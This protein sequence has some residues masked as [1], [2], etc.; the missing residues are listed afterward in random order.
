M[1]YWIVLFFS[2]FVIACKDDTDGTKV[3]MSSITESVYASGIVKAQ[4]QYQVFA[5]VN[6]ILK[7]VYVTE[8]DQI[9]KGAPLFLIENQTS[10]LNT[11]NARLALELSAQNARAN[12]NSLRELELA[13]RLSK[14]KLQNDSIMFTR[15]KNLWDKNIG[16]K[17][18][19]E[20]RQLAYQSSRSAHLSAVSRFRQAKTQFETEYRIA[21]NSL[22]ISK[23]AESNYTVRSET[24][25]VVYDILKEQG[26]LVNTQAPLAILG[27]SAD[28][29]LELQV[30]EYDIVKTRTGQ[31]VLVTMDSYKGRLFHAEVTKIYPIMNERSRTFTVEAVFIDQPAELYP[32]LT[33]EANIIIQTKKKALVIPREYLFDDQYVFTD[34]E[35]KIKTKV[36]T[37]LIDYKFAEIQSGLVSGQLVYKP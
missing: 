20:Q 26:E 5:T 37:G 6:G 10:V 29:I 22:K 11:D 21:Q 27:R 12:S 30:D 32:N 8:G 34:P 36:K 2:L 24:D 7:K 23:E 28:F 9:K 1:K 4:L 31:K 35:K 15:Q 13:V 14:E 19:L 18:D 16:S 17:V 25:G 3:R 33:L